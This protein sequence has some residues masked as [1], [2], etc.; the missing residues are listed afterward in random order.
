V[1]NFSYV[2][3]E[4]EDDEYGSLMADN[5]TFDG[6]VGMLQRKE[7]DVVVA[8]I[9]VSTVR[10]KACIFSMPIYDTKHR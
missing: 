7:V 6:L 4:A 3:S 1:L 5:V 2:L 9:D 10:Q 8:D